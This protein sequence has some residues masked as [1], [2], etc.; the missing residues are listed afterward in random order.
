MGVSKQVSGKGSS[1]SGKCHHT[2]WGGLKSCLIPD[3]LIGP[4]RASFH[5]NARIY[6]FD[7]E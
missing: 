7:P 4:F 1:L 2:S 6:L 3:W 5:S